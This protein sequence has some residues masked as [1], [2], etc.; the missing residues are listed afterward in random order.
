M[1]RTMRGLSEILAKI[2]R[3]AIFRLVS[4]CRTVLYDLRTKIFFFYLNRKM[5]QIEHFRAFSSFFDDF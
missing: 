2:Y 4:S 5:T 3:E 1:I